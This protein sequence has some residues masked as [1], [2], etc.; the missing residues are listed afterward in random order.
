[1]GVRIA[2]IRVTREG[3][4]EKRGRNI[5]GRRRAPIGIVSCNLYSLTKEQAAVSKT[6]AS[7]NMELHYLRRFKVSMPV[8]LTILSIFALL[9]VLSRIFS[10]RIYINAAPQDL[11]LLLDAAYRVHSG[12][13]PHIDFSTTLG[14]F[15][16]AMTALFITLGAGLVN[17]F[18]Y[19]DAFFLIVA[20]LCYLYIQMTR[21]DLAAG[22]FLGV[23][24][25]LALLARM[26]FGDSPDIIIEAMQYN[27][28]CDAFLVLLLLLFIPAHKS[29]T[30]YL[31]I[32]GVLFGAISVFL[33][34]TKFTFG[35]VALGFAP[36]MLIRRRDNVLV[37]ALSAII[38]LAVVTW[39]E[40]VF[41]THFAWLTDL[42]L[43]GGSAGESRLAHT[44]HVFRDNAP[45]LFG[46]ILVPVFIL[47]SLRK[48]TISVALFCIY[49]TLASILLVSYSFQSYVLSLPIAFLFVALD[50][51]TPYSADAGEIRELNTGH[52]L[53]SALSCCLL[54]IEFYPLAVNIAVSSYRSIHAVSFNE[55]N[56]I[57][58]S[59][60]TDGS[61]DD[62]DS[63]SLLLPGESE[64][65][66]KMS[67]YDVLLFGRENKPMDF[68][69]S[70]TSREYRV[71]INSGILAASAGC[72]NYARVSA[73]DIG[74]PFPMLLGWP[75]GGGMI[76]ARPNYQLSRRNHL[77][78]EVMF[79]DVNCVIIPKLPVDIS[80]RDLLLSI[81]WPSLSKSFE[82]SYESD[83]WTVFK[84]RA[85]LSEHKGS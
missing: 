57:L 47:I 73:M 49:V 38:F 83:M 4:S 11:L 28:R 25:L 55:K 65:I 76:F 30:K 82:Q 69:D 59:I 72:G 36:I 40:F 3:G 70:L 15:S 32:D 50:A 6:G 54:V 41:G 29:N 77:P 62:S 18:N 8:L 20:F 75:P 26:N 21:L 58:R 31:T 51:I 46:F 33:F 52:A 16:Y 14:L 13:V 63:T 12:Q 5:S 24:V 71:Y 42:R 60:F 48:L 2:A 44:L 67:K 68:S 39:I 61:Y 23:W 79:R 78:S 37:I 64:L 56:E 80:A 27:R 1:L 19:S 66:D 53:L 22:F 85:Q 17:G 74:N 10:N 9:L 43:A 7:M 35:L 45:E 81:Y 84:R 34:Y